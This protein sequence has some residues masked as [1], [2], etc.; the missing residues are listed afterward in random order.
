MQKQDIEGIWR[1]VSFEEQQR[2]GSWGHAIDSQAQGC[3]SYW[4]NGRMQVLIGGGSRPRLRGEWSE[5]PSQDKADC[6]DKLVAYS[7]S[8]TVEEGRVIHH[9][10]VCWIPNWE[11]RKL[12]RQISFPQRGQLL[13]STVADSSARPRPAQRVLWERWA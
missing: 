3:I 13:L 12:I 5:V 4:P 8:Y 7:G 11:G 10:E 1:L 9:V 2:D 6:L